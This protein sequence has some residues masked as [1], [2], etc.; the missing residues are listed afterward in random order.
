MKFSSVAETYTL[1]SSMLTKQNLVTCMCLTVAMVSTS[2]TNGKL[3]ITCVKI[4]FNVQA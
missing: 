4:D 3:Y 2:F 1:V